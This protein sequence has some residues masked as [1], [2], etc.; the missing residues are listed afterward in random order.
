MIGVLNVCLGGVEQA[1]TALSVND[2]IHAI[3][4]PNSVS[5]SCAEVGG[6]NG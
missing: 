2:Q 5:S 3:D 1:L 6:S 4:A